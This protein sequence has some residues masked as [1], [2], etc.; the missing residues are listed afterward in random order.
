MSEPDWDADEAS[1]P[2]L[3]REPDDVQQERVNMVLQSTK[4]NKNDDHDQQQDAVPA[5]GESASSSSATNQVPAA[6]RA[7]A[8]M[9]D[10]QGQ[11]ESWQWS[12]EAPRRWQ[13][14][15]WSEEDQR[16][17][18]SGQLTS[19]KAPG[20]P[21]AKMW[22]K[23]RGADADDNEKNRLQLDPD[24]FCVFVQ[25]ANALH[26]A[27]MQECDAWGLHVEEKHRN[28]K[29]FMQ[30]GRTIY[31]WKQLEK[32][33]A[34]PL[35]EKQ[36]R[37]P[38]RWQTWLSPRTIDG[39]VDYCCQLFFKFEKVSKSQPF[40]AEMKKFKLHETVHHLWQVCGKGDYAPW[41]Q[42]VSGIRERVQILYRTVMTDLS[43]WIMYG[44]R[45]D[46]EKDEPQLKEIIDPGSAEPS[47]HKWQW[48]DVNDE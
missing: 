36:K 37:D 22:S 39:G 2:P 33:G 13:S 38:I 14:G 18:D 11:W 24:S 26:T 23:H 46:L 7:A 48:A 3:S 20:V 35:T 44:V 32:H 45:P 34:Q 12:E 43:N 4:K 47:E 19:K 40:Y 42:F 31:I 17:W 16:R 10:D 28:L 30:R 41:W 6:G 1:A 25:F 8:S 15:Q 9:E 27:M 29:E 5:A 21:L